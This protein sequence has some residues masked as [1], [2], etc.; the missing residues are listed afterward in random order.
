ML[1]SKARIFRQALDTYP[2][3]QRNHYYWRLVWMPDRVSAKGQPIPPI[4][5]LTG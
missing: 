1:T 5:Q 4:H 2:I 3:N